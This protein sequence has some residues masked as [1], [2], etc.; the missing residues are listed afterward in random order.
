MQKKGSLKVKVI[1][2]PPISD[3][4]PHLSAEEK[5]LRNDFSR[6][7]QEMKMIGKENG[8]ELSYILD[9]LRNSRSID[10]ECFQTAFN[11]VGDPCNKSVL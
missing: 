4:M 7:F 9:E 5:M 3:N 2:K 8:E 1:E 6:L 10:E 11:A